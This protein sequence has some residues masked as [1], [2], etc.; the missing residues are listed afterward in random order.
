MP[1]KDSRSVPQSL[2]D[3]NVEEPRLVETERYSG[4]S[5]ALGGSNPSTCSSN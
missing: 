2:Y 4:G 5:V 1:T 3:S